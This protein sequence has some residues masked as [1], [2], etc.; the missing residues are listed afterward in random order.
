VVGLLRDLVVCVADHDEQ[1]Q[2]RIKRRWLTCS[3]GD[4]GGWLSSSSFFIVLHPALLSRPGGNAPLSTRTPRLV[5]VWDVP[6]RISS[7]WL[8][9][10]ASRAPIALNPALLALGREAHAVGECA[11]SRCRSRWR[12]RR[13]H[14]LSATLR[15]GTFGFRGHGSVFPLSRRLTG[16]GARIPASRAILILS[17]GR[18][19]GAA[20][21]L[22][23]RLQSRPTKWRLTCRPVSSFPSPCCLCLASRSSIPPPSRLFR[24]THTT[25]TTR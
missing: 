6:M 18:G 20:D 13:M 12:R 1:A 16:T 11:R 19:K 2:R 3:G 4:A 5:G 17:C 15:T 10:P 22:L 7:H 21:P 9:S 8:V 24:P 23:R 25:H 14:W